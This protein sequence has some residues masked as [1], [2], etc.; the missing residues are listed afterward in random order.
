MTSVL[1]VTSVVKNTIAFLPRIARITRRNLRGHKQVVQ[2]LNNRYFHVLAP[3]G[4]DKLNLE[5]ATFGLETGLNQQ[6]AIVR[7]VPG[8]QALP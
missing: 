2:G 1:S 6:P 4:T 8:L 3:C 7:I 5:L